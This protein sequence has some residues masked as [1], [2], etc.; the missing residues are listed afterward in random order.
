M[1]S[2]ELPEEKDNAP[3]PESETPEALPDTPDVEDAEYA[4]EAAPEG[5]DVETLQAEI[6]TLNDKLLRALAET[7]N[8]R[9]R[10]VRDKE[11]ASKYAIANFAREMLG[12]GDNLHRALASV[13]ADLRTENAVIEQMM[14]GLEMTERE[15]QNTFE[16]FGIKAIEAMGEKFDHNFHEA[17]F[18]MDDASK[19]AATVVQVVETGYVLK[20]RLLRPAKVGVSKGGPPSVKESA[21][22]ATAEL[23]GD[24]APDSKDSQTAYEDKGGEPGAQIDEEL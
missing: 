23:A 6:V 19:P 3:N 15:I 17:L 1:T 9:R 2:E 5:P 20:D 13:D 14:V 4:E 11:E 22:A 21:K 18:E 10:T 16:R 24:T 12:V 7:E 8:M